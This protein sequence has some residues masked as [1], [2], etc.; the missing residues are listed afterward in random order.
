MNYFI[1]GLKISGIKCIDQEIELQFANKNL[2]I[3][4]F[5]KPHIKAIYGTNG[6]GKS[7]IIHAMNLYYHTVFDSDYLVYENRNGNLKEIINQKTKKAYIDVYYGITIDDK[8]VHILHHTI[9]YALKNENVVISD[10]SLRLINGFRWG[11][12]DKEMPLYEVKD[13]EIKNLSHYLDDYKES[14][15]KSSYNLLENSSLLTNMFKDIDLNILSKENGAMLLSI[16]LVVVM[17]ATTSIYIDDKDFHKISIQRAN[18]LLDQVRQFGEDNLPPRY[19]FT[20][21]YEV[22]DIEEKLLPQYESGVNKIC[23]FLKVFKPEL[24]RIE[25]DQSPIKDNKVRCKKILCYK[26]GTR[27]SSEYESNGIKKLMRLYPT[28]NLIELGGIVFID[29]FDS[30]IHDVYL[31]KLI[32]YFANYTK[33][34]LVFTTHNLGPMEVLGNSNLKHSIDFINN[35]KI[36]SWKKNGNYS[37]VKLYRSGAIPSCPFNLDSADFVRTFGKWLY[38]CA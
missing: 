18:Q 7:S 5:S 30:N 15:Y 3:E 21:D 12:V 4:D 24:D 36:T 20:I 6:T 34:Q 16:G 35:S 17:V 23:E 32:E 27:V 8:K 9:S 26:N 2:K 38:G 11:D 25:I 13:G 14:I 37:V 1:L 28:L 29:E 19:E 10:E 31:C 22:D 33:G